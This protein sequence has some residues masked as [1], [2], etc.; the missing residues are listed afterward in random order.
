MKL[1]EIEV[2]GL[3]GVFDHKIPINLEEGITIIIGENG[4]GKTVILELLES[5]FSK[6][7]YNLLHVEFTEF[8]IV[9]EDDYK[10]IIEQEFLDSEDYGNMPK[11]R[12]EPPRRMKHEPESKLTIRRVSPEGKKIKTKY[13][14]TGALGN[15]SPNIRRTFI[16]D[17]ERTYPYIRRIGV[18]VF[19]DTRRGIRLSI[20]E[21]FHKYGKSLDYPMEVDSLPNWF[22]ER[23]D[24]ININLIKTQ[25]LLVQNLRKDRGYEKAVS[26]YSNELSDN[27]QSHLARSTELSSKL[28]RTY[29]NR[30]VK[31][32]KSTT[33]KGHFHRLNKELESLEAKRNLLDQ[34]GLIETEKDSALS[35]VDNPNPEVIK[36]LLLY[37]EDSFAKLEIFD[38]LAKKIKLFQDIINKRFKHKKLLIDKDRGFIFQS[39]LVDKDQAS[40]TIPVVKLSSG[41]QNELVLFYELLFKMKPDSIILIDEP[42]V[43]LHISWQKKFID[44]LRDV[45]KLTHMEI[46]IATHS[47]DIIG[48]NWGLSVELKGKE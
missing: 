44:D 21:L 30:L 41:E 43:S 6:A 29:P 39:T 1:K 17:I 27:I 13:E 3:F 8:V 25:R 22:K 18:N 47:P 31:S 35:G 11:S 23:V 36:V 26:E 16:R 9:F 46:I 2:N 20:S 33:D 10:W 5:F 40:A 19:E 7:Y 24:R 14:L 42:E 38:E 12:R 48:N 37:I 32:L 28:D 45:I 4:L 34:V 15:I